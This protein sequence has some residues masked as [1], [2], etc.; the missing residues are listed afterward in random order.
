MLQNERQKKILDQL[1]LKNAV[2]V[3]DLAGE[4]A[5]FLPEPAVVHHDHGVAR[6]QGA[7]GAVQFLCGVG[8]QFDPG[9]RLPLFCG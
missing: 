1:K 2:K 6:P 7:Q 8:G 4:L 5:I 9:F 3:H